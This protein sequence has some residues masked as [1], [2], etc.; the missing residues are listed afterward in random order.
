MKI[1]TGRKEKINILLE[2]NH[3]KRLQ[4]YLY[5]SSVIVVVLIYTL[6]MIFFPLYPAKAV[7]TGIISV[8]LGLYLVF[9]KERILRYLSERISEKNRK[10][11]KEQNKLG[12]QKTMKRIVPKKKK[13]F[14]MNIKNKLSFKEKIKK[15]K[16]KFK[17]K[18]NRKN[19]YIEIK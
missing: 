8:I 6:F 5:L 19:T 15:L 1:K 9:N 13:K 10:K 12:Y 17:K 3:Y 11:I 4:L 16:N 18:E 2:N 7:V 14:E